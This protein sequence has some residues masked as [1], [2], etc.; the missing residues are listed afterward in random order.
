MIIKINSYF[1]LPQFTTMDFYNATIEDFV[2]GLEIMMP[3]GKSENYGFYTIKA[4]DAPANFDW[5]ECSIRN[6]RKEDIES[7]GWVCST[8][9]GMCTFYKGPVKWYGTPVPGQINKYWD[10]KLMHDPQAQVIKI[11]AM[12][13]TSWETIFEGMCRN[14][15][16]LQNTMKR[17][18]GIKI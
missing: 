9:N 3:I 17:Q 16:E 10:F 1:A 12:T 13:G 6:L 14:K 7:F 2:I 5:A 18:L 8:T 15:I 11:R 4:T